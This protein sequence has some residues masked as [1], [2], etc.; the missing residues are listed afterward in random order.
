MITA[1]GIYLLVSLFFVLGSMIEFAIVLFVEQNSEAGIDNHYSRQIMQRIVH[2]R[3]DENNSIPH[4][5]FGSAR[6]AFVMANDLRNDAKNE[7]M[8]CNI[9]KERI[10]VYS[11]ASGL[12][13]QIDYAAFVLFN[14]AYI[15]FN[16][17]Y[18]VYFH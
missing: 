5:T 13:K 14:M 18:F 15:G 7:E 17:F 16:L 6:L 10:F 4:C 12:T 8:E 3:E 2:T 9:R 1:L 11:T